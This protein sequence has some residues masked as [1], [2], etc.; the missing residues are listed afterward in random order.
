[1]QD[2]QA[3]LI[4]EATYHIYNRANGS[5]AL[6]LSNENYQYFLK[7]YSEYINPIADTFC[8]C[9]M[10]N[11]FHFLVRIKEEAVLNR[12]FEDKLNRLKAKGNKDLQG[13]Q[14][15][16]GLISQQFSNF[17]NAYA[18][19]FNKQQ[20]RKGSLFRHPF[21]RKQI[22]DDIYLRNLIHYIHY[23]P[24]AGGFTETLDAWRYS[25][26]HTIVSEGHTSVASEAVIALFDDR[27]NLNIIIIKNLMNL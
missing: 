18:K 16:E 4:P 19:A 8:Y 13:F 24:I 15:L 12:F 17:F 5:E 11:H 23:N 2:N 21:K 10:P 20:N 14:N 6:F 27:D 7:K 25:S 22:T 9:L 26:Y 1:M 3:I